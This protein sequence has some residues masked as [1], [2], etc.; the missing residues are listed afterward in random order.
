MKKTYTPTHCQVKNFSNLGVFSHSLAF[1]LPFRCKFNPFK[2]LWQP[3]SCSTI[4]ETGEM[5]DFQQISQHGPWSKIPQMA[6]KTPTQT[7]PLARLGSMNMFFTASGET[8]GT[9]TGF[10]KP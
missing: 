4:G 10:E 5:K 3:Q 7:K 9:A 1:T 2:H 6:R 8:R